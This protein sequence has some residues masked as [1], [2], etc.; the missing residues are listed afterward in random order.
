MPDN[1]MF[2][3]VV[4]HCDTTI[5]A[6]M[7]VVVLTQMLTQLNQPLTNRMCK[8]HADEYLKRITALN[9]LTTEAAKRD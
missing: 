8:E 5:R 4:K 3:T 9:Q 1:C 6:C 2:C 7:Q